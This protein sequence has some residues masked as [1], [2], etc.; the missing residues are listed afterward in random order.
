MGSVSEAAGLST[1][2]LMETGETANGRYVRYADGTQICTQTIDLN[3][4]S[5]LRLTAGW[6]YPIPF[7]AGAPVS[8]SMSVL[9]EFAVTPGPED[10]GWMGAR[11]GSGVPET[12]ASLRLYR[13][14]GGI[15]FGTGDLMTVYAC[16]TGRW[17]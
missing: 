6:V 14:S 8:V 15:D 4:T 3:Y 10:L 13:R 11:I 2:A 1:G 9:N 5:P 17:R 12:S 16:A 7:L